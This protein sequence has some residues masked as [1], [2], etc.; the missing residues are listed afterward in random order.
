MHQPRREIEFIAARL[1]EEQAAA[2]SS[3][4]TASIHQ[5]LADDYAAALTA[6]QRYAQQIG[7]PNKA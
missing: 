6:Y 1:A 4:E 3:G 2:A 7:Q 5:Q